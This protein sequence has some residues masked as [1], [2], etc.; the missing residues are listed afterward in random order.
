MI[1]F[2]WS[3]CLS[4]FS[5]EAFGN[6]NNKWTDT[7]MG[8]VV[9]ERSSHKGRNEPGCKCNVTENELGGRLWTN[10]K[11]TNSSEV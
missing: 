1:M 11:A 8:K 5:Y 4:V 2:K 7:E 3:C 6:V 10:R 9:G